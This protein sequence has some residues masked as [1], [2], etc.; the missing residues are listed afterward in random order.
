MPPGVGGA[1]LVVIAKDSD[2]KVLERKFIVGRTE[3]QAGGA[4]SA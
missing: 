2:G 1:E 3:G 4:M